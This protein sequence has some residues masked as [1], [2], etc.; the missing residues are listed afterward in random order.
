MPVAPSTDFAYGSN[1]LS[2]KGNKASS[3]GKFNSWA[4][5]RVWNRYLW[6]D[7]LILFTAV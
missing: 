1:S 2:T 6:P 4:L 5:V 3:T 7:L